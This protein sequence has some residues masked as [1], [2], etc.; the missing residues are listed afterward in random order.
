MAIYPAVGPVTS[1]R[2][3][4]TR[5]GSKRAAHYNSDLIVL[6]GI[7]TI[8]VEWTPTPDGDVPTVTIQLDPRR[9]HKLG[10]KEAEYMYELCVEDPRALD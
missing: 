5:R 9:L 4:M 8:V 7:P 1:V 6:D 10:W 2:H 3:L